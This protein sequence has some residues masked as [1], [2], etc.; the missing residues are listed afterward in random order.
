[1]AVLLLLVHVALMPWSWNSGSPAAIMGIVGFV[2]LV[3]VSIAPRVPGLNRVLHLGYRGWKRT[4]RCI[5]IFLIMGLAHAM[6][7]GAVTRC[8]PLVF[9]IMVG[10]FVVGIM[11][12]LH[13]ELVVPILRRRHRYLVEAVR[14]VAPGL[15]EISMTAKSRSLVFVAGQFAFV[16]F[17]RLGL[18]EWHPFTIS[19]APGSE[20]L[21]FTVRTSGDYTRRLHDRLTPGTRAVVEGAYGLFDHRL[22]DGAQVWIAGGIGITPFLSWL[23]A[24]DGPL[25]YTVDLH[26]AVRTPADAA[27]AEELHAIASSQPDLT[28]NINISQKDGSLTMHTVASGLAG[29]VADRHVFLCGPTPMVRAFETEF[30]RAGVPYSRIHFEHFA[31]R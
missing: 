1:M 20:R 30:A 12:Y 31:F 28:V 8:S 26:Y 5:G 15:L 25:P 13:L 11:L 29:D 23:R 22:G 2:V 6:L 17:R 18:R 9:G 19:S 7:S 24:V 10:A 3:L 27:F 14:E 21:I 16:S 4:H